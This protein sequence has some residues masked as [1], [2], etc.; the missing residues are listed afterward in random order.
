[1]CRRGV[2]VIAGWGRVARVK[3]GLGAAL[4][5][6]GKVFGG[7]RPAGWR[8]RAESEGARA[9]GALVSGNP[10]GGCVNVLSPQ[11]PRNT[12]STYARANGDV[13]IGPRW[14]TAGLAVVAERNGSGCNPDQRHGISP[15]VSD[16]DSLSIAIRPRNGVSH[17]PHGGWAVF[18]QLGTPAVW[19]CKKIAAPFGANMAS[20]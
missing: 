4:R 14:E 11:R 6:C 10:Y 1:M 19:D 16:V 3:P 20:R 9:L 15:S 12:N 5:W 17:N 13:D 7:I 18:F 8:G 2:G